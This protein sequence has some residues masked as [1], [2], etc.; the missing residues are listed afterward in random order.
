M[1]AS[2]ESNMG[3]QAFSGPAPCSCPRIWGRNKRI[4]HL[5]PLRSPIAGGTSSVKVLAFRPCWRRTIVLAIRNPSRSPSPPNR[6]S[7]PGRAPASVTLALLRFP[8]FQAFAAALRPG[9]RRE[10]PPRRGRGLPTARARAQS[11]D[12]GLLAPH[13]GVVLRRSRPDLV[14]DCGPG[15][16]GL[17]GVACHLARSLWPLPPHVLSAPKGKA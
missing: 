16:R 8:Q 14:V 2:N 10:L 12:L 7:E 3:L 1:V 9:A 5:P 6:H 13:R 4:E 17:A 15:R 11:L